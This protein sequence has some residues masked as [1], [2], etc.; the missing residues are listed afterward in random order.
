MAALG[1]CVIRHALIEDRLGTGVELRESIA[2]Y[3]EVSD[4][5]CRDQTATAVVTPGDAKSAITAKVDII[6]TPQ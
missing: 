5:D 6:E 1:E 4:A 3:P 2:S